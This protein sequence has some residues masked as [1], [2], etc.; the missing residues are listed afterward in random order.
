MMSNRQK[1]PFFLPAIDNGDQFRRWNRSWLL[2]SRLKIFQGEV[3]AI[4]PNN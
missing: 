2:S 1:E 3:F 4:E